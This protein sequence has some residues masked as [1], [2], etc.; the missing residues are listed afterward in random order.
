[1]AAGPVP[2]ETHQRERDTIRRQGDAQ[3][4][5]PDG[6]LRGPELPGKYGPE[7]VAWYDN[8]RR[9]AQAQLFISTDW[10]RLIMLAPLVDAY[11][12]VPSTAMLGEIRL[13]EERLG[14]T[15]VDRM[16]AKIRVDNGESQPDATVTQLRAV[17]RQG[18]KDRLKK[19]EGDPLPF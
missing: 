12:R 7:T 14:A 8:W 3:T 9:S 11:Y 4:V 16:R 5:T 13:N 18:T 2:K 10:Q 6:V 19:S 17:R 1:M 15:Y